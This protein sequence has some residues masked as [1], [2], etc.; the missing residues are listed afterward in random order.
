MEI[1]K[2]LITSGRDNG[3]IFPALSAGRYFLS[4]Q[5]SSGHYCSPRET[6]PVT[7]YVSMEMC[8]FTPTSQ[9]FLDIRRSSIIR[10]FHRYSELIDYMDSNGEIFGWVPVELINELYVY[11]IDL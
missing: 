8:I 2:K 11:L 9:R 1:L 4:I 10:S 6:L 3:N 5:A 7:H